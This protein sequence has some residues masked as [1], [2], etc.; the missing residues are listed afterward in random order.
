MNMPESQKLLT[1]EEVRSKRMIRIALIAL[2]IVELIAMVAVFLK[3][4]LG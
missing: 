1:D 4:G 2:S 3:K